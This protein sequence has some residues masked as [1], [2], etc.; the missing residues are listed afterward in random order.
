MDT[1]IKASHVCT[2]CETPQ[3]NTAY[4]FGYKIPSFIIIILMVVV[5]I[6]LLFVSLAFGPLGMVLLMVYLW[7]VG[8][9]CRACGRFKLIPVQSPRAMQIMQKNGWENH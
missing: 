5:L 2:E 1:E 4:F 7:S 6:P 3:D 9:K 8:K